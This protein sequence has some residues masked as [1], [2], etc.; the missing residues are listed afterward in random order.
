VKNQRGA[1]YFRLWSVAWKYSGDS[2]ARIFPTRQEV[3]FLECQRATH[4]C[5]A[6]AANVV[7]SGGSFLRDAGYREPRIEIALTGTGKLSIRIRNRDRHPVSREDHRGEALA[8]A[9]SF[10][11][12]YGAMNR[13]SSSW[14][15]VLSELVLPVETRSGRAGNMQWL[16]PERPYL[17]SCLRAPALVAAGIQTDC[18]LRRRRLA[19][20]G[21]RPQTSL[22]LV[23][24][25]A[26]VAS[27]ARLVFASFAHALLL[28]E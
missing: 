16:T 3:F 10:G 4:G 23:H 5:G 18:R 15:R 8:N 11:I 19:H 25:A 9:E 22:G 13:M 14:L 24:H 26:Y 7:V 21:A 2:G 27:S 6:G 1:F 20:P 28:Q 17:P 12:K